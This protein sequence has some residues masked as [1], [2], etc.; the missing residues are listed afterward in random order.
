MDSSNNIHTYIDSIKGN[1]NEEL[2]EIEDEIQRNYREEDEKSIHNKTE[3]IIA[4]VIE[5]TENI[6]EKEQNH[7]DE[8]IKETIKDMGSNQEETDANKENIEKL[9]TAYSKLYKILTNSR[10]N[11]I[12]LMKRCHE[13]T[14]DIVAN[15][16]KVQSAIQMT[17]E[18]RKSAILMKTELEKAWKLLE[19]SNQNEAIA[20]DALLQIKSDYTLVRRL[21]VEAGVPT[22]S[23]TNE[24]EN[25]EKKL[26]SN[27][28]T[29]LKEK[30]EVERKLTS[31]NNK[32]I[33]LENTQK[34]LKKKIEQLMC[35]IDD[36]RTTIMDMK[37]QYI[38]LQSK[39]NRLERNRD[40]DRQKLEEFQ[41]IVNIK[42]KE[43]D[44]FHNEIE[45]YKEKEKDYEQKL[46]DE[47]Y[48]HDLTHKEK[49]EIEQSLISANQEIEEHVITYT[50]ITTE[51]QNLKNELKNIEEEYQKVKEDNKNLNKSKET[52]QKKFKQSEETKLESENQMAILKVI[53]IN[54]K[55]INL[56]VYIIKYIY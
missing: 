3:A 18:S 25:E 7:L 20:Q 4:K 21:A 30:Y 37:E 43:I 9:K 5:G 33:E 14:T 8:V 46:K 2:K 23:F 27:L 56:Y 15:A 16:T 45:N 31:S 35:N 29:V 17:Y 51:K 53:T 34:E 6:N 41:N 40:D 44:T 26:D 47:K 49:D 22:E 11:E 19:I 50:K 48:A 55:K 36:Q 32:I 42:D 39:Y 13:L 52:L 10:N 38:T 12:Y 24:N 1:N 28:D 54:Y